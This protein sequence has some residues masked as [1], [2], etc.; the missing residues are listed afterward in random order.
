VLTDRDVHDQ[1]QPELG[2]VP[3][4][5]ALHEGAEQQDNG[6]QQQHHGATVG[7]SVI[8]AVI[9]T[10][11]AGGEDPAEQAGGGDDEQDRRVPSAASR[12]AP[13]LARRQAALDEQPDTE[14][15]ATVDGRLGR[16][17]QAEA[18]AADDQHRHHQP[19][20]TQRHQRAGGAEG[21]DLGAPTVSPGHPAAAA[22]S[23]T[24][25]TAGMNP[26]RNNCPHWSRRID[27]HDDGGRILPSVPA[28]PSAQ[29][30]PFG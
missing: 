14:G 13:D 19:A 2:G 3:S 26:A 11:C 8:A 25:S 5:P 16:R 12:N 6:Q 22:I 15:V 17:R 21:I 4:S 23:S 20:A 18:D 29:E 27:H 24:A 30:K 1:Q 10:A 28:Q 9:A 7:Q